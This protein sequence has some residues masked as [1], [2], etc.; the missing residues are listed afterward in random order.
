MKP[1][2][3][4]V[5]TWDWKGNKVDLFFNFIVFFWLFF[6]GGLCLAYLQVREFFYL[7][8]IIWIIIIGLFLIKNFPKRKVIWEKVR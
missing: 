7:Y 5:V 3:K 8:L 4:K 6:M 1:Q 2:Y